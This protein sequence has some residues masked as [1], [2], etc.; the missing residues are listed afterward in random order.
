MAVKPKQSLMDYMVI[1]ISPAL[2]MVMVGS[3]MFYLINVFYQGQH[4]ARLSFIM[5]MFVMAIVCIARISMEQGIE[6][7]TLFAIPLALVTMVAMARFVQITGPLSQYS[8]IINFGL[9]ALVWWSAH[10]LT[11]DCTLIDDSQD[12]SGEGLL[13]HIG[14]DGD[15]VEHQASARAT[16]W[17]PRQASHVGRGGRARGKPTCGSSG[18]S[19]WWTVATGRIRQVSGSCTTLWPRCRCLPSASGGFTIRARG[20]RRFATSWFT[21]A[22]RSGC[23]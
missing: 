8:M 16:S 22:A 1:G 7:A 15:T 20:W 6:Y 11:W 4:D 17:S 12:S 14:M 5:A 9:I 10:K 13:Q 2:I 3:L 19:G 21:W 18:G 23:C